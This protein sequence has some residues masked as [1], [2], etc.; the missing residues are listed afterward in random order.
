MP[1]D[2]P[3]RLPG[4]LHG[5]LDAG[6]RFYHDLL[7]DDDLLADLLGVLA[8]VERAVLAGEHWTPLLGE[9]RAALRSGEAGRARIRATVRRYG[10]DTDDE[11]PADDDDRE[12]E[13]PTRRSQLA[14]PLRD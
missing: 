11:T 3:P 1:T 10:P 5:L 7:H 4:T 14:L 12:I 13:R 6:V 8:M 2:A 9:V